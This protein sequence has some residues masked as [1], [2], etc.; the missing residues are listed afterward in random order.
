MLPALNLANCWK[1][2]YSFIISSSAGC[3]LYYKLISIFRDYSPKFVC[4]K[5]RGWCKLFVPA[6]NIDRKLFSV[7]RKTLAPAQSYRNNEEFDAKFSSYLAGIIEGDGSIIVPKTERSPKGDLYYPS[8]Q[9]LFD[10]RDFPLALI[11]QSKLSHGSI[12]KKKGYNAYV[13]TINKLEGI[14]LIANIINGYMRTPKI[15]ALHR[16]ID[17]LNQRFD[18][19]IRKKNK[20]IS[21]INSNS[22]LAGFIDADGHFS[23]RTTL[24][25]ERT[26]YPKIECKFELSQRQN[27]HNNENNLE[28]LSIIAN[29]LS[30]TVKET[31]MNKPKPEYRVRTTNVDSN[32]ILVEYLEKYPLFSSKYLNYKDWIKVLSYFKAKS[33][34]KSES[35]KVIVEIKA[36]MNNKRTEFNWDHLNNFYNLY[37]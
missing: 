4:F 22:W 7:K 29:F 26:K 18:L 21:D 30:S 13:L 32:Y 9:I 5:N 12:S 36:Q 1:Q 3:L 28:Y 2:I 27:D 31:R 24:V 19:N 25:A 15:Y 8:I 17:W 20:D 10:S 6:L 37:K 33:H 35:I 23:V 14:F 16:L 34:T 11:L